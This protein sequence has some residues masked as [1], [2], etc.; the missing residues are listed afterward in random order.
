[1]G[2]GVLLNDGIACLKDCVSELLIDLFEN[3]VLLTEHVSVPKKS[4]SAHGKILC[5]LEVLPKYRILNV[6]DAIDFQARKYPFDAY[7]PHR[8]T[9]LVS[10][11]RPRCT[12]QLS[13]VSSSLIWVGHT[14]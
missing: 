4:I 13:E 3:F 2:S 1:M 8:K 7:A 9:Y 6:G 10:D 5:K 14:L 12:N 11:K